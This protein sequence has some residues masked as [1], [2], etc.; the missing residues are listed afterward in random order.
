[1]RRTWS[2]AGRLRNRTPAFPIQ[3]KVKRRNGLRPPLRRFVSES[4]DET[5]DRQRKRTAG[6]AGEGIRRSP[7]TAKARGTCGLSV[8]RSIASFFF[9]RSVFLGASTDGVRLRA[10][11]A[12]RQQEER[13][14][15]RARSTS[16]VERLNRPGRVRRSS[17][18]FVRMEGA[19]GIKGPT[20]ARMRSVVI[21]LLYPK[22]G[23][24]A[25]GVRPRGYPESRP[26]VE[27]HGL[28][29]SRN[30]HVKPLG[31]SGFRPENP[32]C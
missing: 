14:T 9:V 29:R 27:Q 32:V 17:V 23:R 7:K 26:S 12:K 28:G 4:P 13:C 24:A 25:S 30:R 11:E 31:F 1:M 22:R 6:F 21:G 8:I 2:S 5:Q 3:N 16:N 15:D 20:C 10:A 18:G 19:A